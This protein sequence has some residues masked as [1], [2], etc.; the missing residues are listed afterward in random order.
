VGEPR[1]RR[2][3]LEQRVKE[4]LEELSFRRQRDKALFVT[5]EWTEEPLRAVVVV[6][7]DIDR[8]GLVRMGGSVVIV[9]PAVEELLEA[10]PKSVLSPAQQIYV[11]RI[12]MGVAGASFQ[13]LLEPGRKTPL[14]WRVA[15]DEDLEPAVEGFVQAVDG[16]V[17]EWVA[18][19]A[20]VGAVQAA[21]EQERGR[22]GEGNLVRTVA[23]LEALGGDLKGALA[24]LDRYRNAPTTRDTAE[25]VQ[26]FADWLTGAVAPSG[27]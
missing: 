11:G 18:R 3:R 22:P 26:A 21:V 6:G 17:R 15:D 25:R 24:R 19:H 10:A 5:D 27:R 13:D 2:K 23:L 16:P 12:P 8:S 1:E 7:V 4:A 9:A 14:E 20:T